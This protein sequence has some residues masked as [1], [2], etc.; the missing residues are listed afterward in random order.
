MMTKLSFMMKLKMIGLFSILNL[1]QMTADSSN[2]QLDLSRDNSII[3]PDASKELLEGKTSYFPFC[4]E[5]IPHWCRI[6]ACKS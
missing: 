6:S 5:P 1:F 4:F 2:E 3:L